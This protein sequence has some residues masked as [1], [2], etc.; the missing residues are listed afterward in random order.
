MHIKLIDFYYDKWKE[1]IK[2]SQKQKKTIKIE[3]NGQL[4]Y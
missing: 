1:Y 4:F 3:K 2:S